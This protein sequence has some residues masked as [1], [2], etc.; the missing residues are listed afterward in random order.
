MHFTATNRKKVP[1][2]CRKRLTNNIIGCSIYSI[3]WKV[4]VYLD[5]HSVKLLKRRRNGRQQRRRCA[6]KPR[7]KMVGIYTPSLE[8]TANER[9]IQNQQKKNNYIQERIAQSHTK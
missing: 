9:S 3:S 4:Q 6:W 8:S 1:K 5:H 2:S 7:D